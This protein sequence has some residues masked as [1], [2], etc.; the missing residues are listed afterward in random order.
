MLRCV[1]PGIEHP[2]REDLPVKELPLTSL[3]PGVYRQR[4]IGPSVAVGAGNDA[5]TKSISMI[6]ELQQVT[7]Q[8]R[9]LYHY[10]Y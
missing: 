7:L 8:F 6:N 1:P 10:L 3:L 2:Q 4:P 9:Q 5:A